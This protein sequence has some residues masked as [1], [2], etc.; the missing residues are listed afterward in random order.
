MK[1]LRVEN[2]KYQSPKS[3]KFTSQKRGRPS[4]TIGQKV[5]RLVQD[6]ALDSDCE[7]E[8]PCVKKSR[9]GSIV[10]KSKCNLKLPVREGQSLP[11]IKCQIREAI[12][13]RELA[14]R[15]VDELHQMEKGLLLGSRPNEKHQ[16]KNCQTLVTENAKLR[17]EIRNLKY[18]VE[19]MKK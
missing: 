14:V 12:Q 1:A 15:R 2:R 9:L 8:K 16:C 6:L 17:E 18:C 11:S 13:A 3:C 5:D 19:I 10:Q 4:H 7:N